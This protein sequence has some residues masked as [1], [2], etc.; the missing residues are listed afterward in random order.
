[1]KQRTARPSAQVSGVVLQKGHIRR[2]RA[3][4][5]KLVAQVK[6]ILAESGDLEL[7]KG[8]DADAW[9]ARWVAEPLP[10]LGERHPW[11]TGTPPGNKKQSPACCR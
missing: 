11:I 1:M 9:V 10:A 3:F 5:A 2:K 7:V 6:T 8:F 4:L